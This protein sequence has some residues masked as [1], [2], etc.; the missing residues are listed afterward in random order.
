MLISDDGVGINTSE[1][2]KVAVKRG[3]ITPDK[4]E[5]M[6]ELETLSLIGRSGI[7]TSP[8][9]T[10][11]SG[12]GLGMAIVMEK[13]EKI[14]GS[15]SIE[16]H[17]DNGTSFRITLPMTV[18]VFRGVIVRL[19]DRLFALP[20]SNVERVLRIQKENIKYIENRE[21]IQID[22]QVLS[23]VRLRD[24]FAFH[25]EE[26]CI[27]SPDY[28]NVLILTYAEK[29]IAFLVDEIVNEQE[30]LVK[31]LGTQLSRVRNII[32]ASIMATGRMVP[33]INIADLMKSAIKVIPYKENAVTKTEIKKQSIMVVE[34]SITSRMLLKNILEAAGYYVKTAVDGID[35]FNTLKTEKFDLVV[36]DV[37][38]PRM[39]GF[40]LT[41]KI[42][43]DKKLTDLPLILVTALESREHKE[44]GV[45]VG[46]S[47]YIVKSSFDQSNL[48]ETIHRLI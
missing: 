39:N 32:G 40:D 37:D 34:D 11:I 27:S 42:R 28:S 29:R 7:S 23:L 15:I 38:M 3:L 1:I 9:I 43:A 8:I 4:A 45:E 18:A 14:R 10:D 33:V 44:R 17:P 21:T 36:S 24:I 41:A 26:S 16:T 48:L 20:T 47:A 31:S 12:R 35:A 25:Y 19:E 5:K 30:V 22:G 6:S 46:A 2:R 13:V